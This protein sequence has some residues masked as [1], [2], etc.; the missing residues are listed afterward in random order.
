MP[1]LNFT[2]D[3]LRPRKYAAMHHATF[4]FKPWLN[5]GVFEGV[6]SGRKNH[7]EFQYLNPLI[8]YRTIEQ[9]IGS[10]DNAVIGLDARIIPFKRTELYG[11]LLI[12]EFIF[13][14]IKA[15]KG[16][17]R[18]KQAIQ[19]GIKHVDVA[20]VKNL[21]VQL[22]FNYIRPFTYSYSDSIADYS[23]YNQSLAH[24]NGANLSELIAIVRYQPLPR[25]RFSVEAINRIQGLDT[26]ATFSNGG[27]IF[28][29]YTLR[30][31]L[32]T[33]FTM[34]NGNKT[35][36]L[37][38]NTNASYQVYNNAYI[39]AGVTINN[40]SNITTTAKSTFAYLGARLNY[41]RRKYNY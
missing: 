32:E 30:N 15:G 7:F 38:V 36:T 16:D 40:S 33:G 6:I 29:D 23:H 3:Q 4:H 1:Y 14:A 11:Q 20:G 21:D 8:F 24:P 2:A 19:A 17:W 25:L 9:A 28:K 18:N 27:N 5:V 39:D 26:S 34:Y 31:G 22:E 37:Y 10:P 35:R 13:G 12:D 41:A